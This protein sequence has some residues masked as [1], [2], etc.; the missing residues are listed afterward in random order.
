MTQHGTA[1]P[2]FLVVIGLIGHAL[3]SQPSKGHPWRILI[4][5]PQRYTTL[6]VPHIKKLETYF[7]LFIFLDF[8][9]MCTQLKDI[10]L[11]RSSLFLLL[12]EMSSEM[13]LLLLL[14]GCEGGGWDKDLIERGALCSWGWDRVMNHDNSRIHVWAFHVNLR[15]L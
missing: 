5:F 7:A 10:I 15:F 3:S 6:I 12:L 11:T 13:L 9:T 4:I 8:R 2:L 14:Q 1:I